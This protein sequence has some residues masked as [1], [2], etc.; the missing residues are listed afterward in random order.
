MKHLTYLEHD[1]ADDR[2]IYISCSSS[3]EFVLPLTV[4][5]GSLFAHVDRSW[6]VVVYIFDGGMRTSDRNRMLRSLNTKNAD[7]KF[8]KIRDHAQ[9]KGLE[10]EGHFSI[11]SSYRVIGTM[12]LPKS[13]TKVIHLD[14]DVI[15]SEDISKLWSVDIGE[16]YVLAV[17]EQGKDHQYVSSKGGMVHYRRFGIDP[18][19]KYFN[20]GIMV[21]NLEKWRQDS[22][23]ERT[24]D[25]MRE[26]IKYIQWYDQDALNV[27][28]ANKW[29][30]LDHRWNLLTQIFSNSGWEEGPLES[31]KKYRELVEHPYI[32]HFNTPGKPWH[33]DDVHPYRNLFIENLKKT[34]WYWTWKL[35]MWKSC[36]VKYLLPRGFTRFVKKML[37]SKNY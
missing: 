3:K 18:G 31:E 7:I 4:M 9:L 8:L 30:E 6:K 2:T 12:M 25:F 29:G 28:L 20:A 10:T 32:I 26:N 23:A 24:I 13:I 5:L 17:Q 33:F 37:L 16:N 19:T 14:S 35:Q 36:F 34:R 22:I 1:G 11:A 27:V 21:I 15:L